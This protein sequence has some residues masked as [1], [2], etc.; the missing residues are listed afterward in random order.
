MS[1]V[2]SSLGT[3][4]GASVS[5][6]LAQLSFPKPTSVSGLQTSADDTTMR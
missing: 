2:R 6:N 5:G 1:K 3:C 4:S